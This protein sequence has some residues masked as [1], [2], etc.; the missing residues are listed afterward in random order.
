MISLKRALKVAVIPTVGVLAACTATNQG[1]NTPPPA[2]TT[3]ALNTTAALSEE[4]NINRNDLQPHGGICVDI[5]IS[6][7][8]TLAE[9]RGFADSVG[10]AMANEITT[11]TRTQPGRTDNQIDAIR[12]T[13]SAIPEISA[14]S[15]I[16]AGGTQADCARRGYSRGDDLGTMFVTG[17]A[18]DMFNGRG[19]WAEN[20]LNN[21]YPFTPAPAPAN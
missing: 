5:S 6:Q 19:T 8:F 2:P 3:A 17:E 14:Q 20:G 12:E 13:I 11:P 18:D 15:R 10:A 7:A 4:I 21:T 9:A 16:Y 1:V